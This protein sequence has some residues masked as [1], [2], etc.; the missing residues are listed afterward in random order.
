MPCVAEVVNRSLKAD[1]TDFTRSD[2]ES[3]FQQQFGEYHGYYGCY[4]IYS[5]RSTI[6]RL[7]GL[8]H[9]VSNDDTWA[10]WCILRKRAAIDKMDYHMFQRKCLLGCSG[11]LGEVLK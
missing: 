10:C 1:C 2:S 7:S 8:L 9:K 11:K 5:D 4:L 6:I 3:I